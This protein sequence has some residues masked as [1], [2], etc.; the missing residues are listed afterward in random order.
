MEQNESFG[1]G[2]GQVSNPESFRL[3]PKLPYF[4]MEFRGKLFFFEFGNS[5]KFK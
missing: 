5:R 1:P 3:G 4:L 2:F